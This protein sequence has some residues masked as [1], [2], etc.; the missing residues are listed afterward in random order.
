[1]LLIAAGSATSPNGP[2]PPECRFSVS[3]QRHRCGEQGHAE[4]RPRDGSARRD[5][6]HAGEGDRRT[7]VGTTRP[8]ERFEPS[9]P[10]KK[11]LLVEIVWSTFPACPF[12][13]SR[14]HSPIVPQELHSK[15]PRLRKRTF[16]ARS[17]HAALPSANHIGSAERDTETTQWIGSSRR[18]S[19]ATVK[20]A[21]RH[22]LH[23]LVRKHL[24]RAIGRLLT[25]ARSRVI[26]D[27]IRKDCL[28][29]GSLSR[30]ETDL[31]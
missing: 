16:M 4:R 17:C 29:L 6:D 20:P 3:E 10:V 1:L 22:L 7:D 13:L 27:T 24:P 8:P 2:A 28:E 11:S 19:L 5:A 23:S 25:N 18:L 14:G 31:K 21:P 26:A 9:I 30:T 15:A 12:L